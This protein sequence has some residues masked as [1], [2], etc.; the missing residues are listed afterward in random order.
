MT[1]QVST[2]TKVAVIAAL[3]E[4]FDGG[5]IRIFTGSPPDTAD[6]AEIGTLLGVITKNG[7]AGVGLDFVAQGPYLIKDLFDSWMLT[8][9]VTGSMGWWRLVK[10]PADTG[11]QSFNA[12]RIDGTISTDPGSGAEF[13]VDALGVT[14]GLQ[15][16]IDAFTYTIPPVVGA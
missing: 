7:A 1:L 10:D 15:Y 12:A 5:V 3:K 2:E 9:D 14:A 13:I 16:S 8:A 4:V 6:D 11:S